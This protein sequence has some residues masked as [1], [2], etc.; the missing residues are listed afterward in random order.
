MAQEVDDATLQ[1]AATIFASIGGGKI[2]SKAASK[3]ARKYALKQAALLR[4]TLQGVDAELA[5]KD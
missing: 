1:A 4:A 3:K 5:K 2:L